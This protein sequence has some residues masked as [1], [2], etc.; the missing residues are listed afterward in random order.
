MK[1]LWCGAAALIDEAGPTASHGGSF[2]HQGQSHPG[3]HSPIIDFAATTRFTAPAYWE[4]GS[5]FLQRINPRESNLSPSRTKSD[6]D[7]LLPLLVW[8]ASF[9]DGRTYWCE[10]ASRR[11]MI[12]KPT[13]STALSEELQAKRFL[14]SSPRFR[15]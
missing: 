14:F 11:H 5:I 13:R 15:R 1:A 7:A 3:E 9:L 10:G 8:Q 4:F 12:R 2:V 6:G